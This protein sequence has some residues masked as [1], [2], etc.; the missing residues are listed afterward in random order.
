MKSTLQDV[1]R[2]LELK[3]FFSPTFVRAVL[4]K[5]KLTENSPERKL[6]GNKM[7]TQAFNAVYACLRT[8]VGKAEGQQR[9]PLVSDLLEQTRPELLR[10]PYFG[11]KGLQWIET[12]LSLFGLSLKNSFFTSEGM[13]LSS[14]A[15]SV[16][17]LLT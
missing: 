8:D 7:P 15:Q 12:Y 5:K 14:E 9:E 2:K 4:Q 10:I 13:G 17:K 11:E 16:L 3:E 6:L 1:V